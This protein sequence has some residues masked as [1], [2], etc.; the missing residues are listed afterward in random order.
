M[1]RRAF[2]LIELLLVTGI[3]SVLAGVTVTAVHP[4]RQLAQARNT[5][6]RAHI[7]AMLNAVH[8]YQVQ[9]GGSL[10]AGIDATVRMIGAAVAGCDVACFGSGESLVQ[11]AFVDDTQME[12]DAGTHGGTRWG[13]GGG[14]EL[15]GG[16]A[17]TFTSSV[18]DAGKT[19]A[20]STLSWVPVAPYGKELPSA[21][22]SGYA[23]GNADMSG[24]AVL[25][26]QNENSGQ[27]T[28]SS[29]NGKHSSLVAGVTYGGAG[30]FRSALH[31]DG[32]D[33]VEFPSV[34]SHVPHKSSL[35]E[36]TAE[37]WMRTSA[38]FSSVAVFLTQGWGGQFLLQFNTNGEIGFA[39]HQTRSGGTDYNG[40]W[41]G[42]NTSPTAY[43]DGQWHH[44]AGRYHRTENTIK[45]YVDGVLRN[46]ATLDA[47][48]YL[49][50]PPT[51]HPPL[52]GAASQ[53]PN[54]RIYFFTGDLDEAA[55][56]SRALS[57]QEIL[58]RYQRGARTLSL[59]ARS[60]DDAVC[61]GEAFIGPDGTAGSSFSE[62]TNP[63]GGLPSFS[64]SSATPNR[65][66]Q[67]RVT[68]GADS[69]SLTPILASVTVSNT[70]SGASVTPGVCLALTGSLVPTFIP[71]VPHDPSLGGDDRTYY[72]VRQTAQG[73]TL[74]RACAAE[75]GNV[76]EVTR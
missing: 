34:F 32:N 45:L 8:Q 67:Y 50:D 5:Q 37:V 48:E 14:L 52:L 26:H 10:P 42:V 70:A 55:L 27:I 19:A 22:E 51:T 73:R 57:D 25:W 15:S 68:M 46:Q 49:A 59:Q 43:N 31:F 64:L 63:G 12:F 39:V 11:N 41:Y 40:A 69:A 7:S 30:K 36:L 28:D 66:V 20:W 74:V 9:N 65:Y 47:N 71:S 6:R 60:C 13:G 33:Y 72:A 23:S 75:L 2:T 53:Y 29:G 21:S 54:N 1:H 76:I 16:T 35:N 24:L 3:V 61:S 58:D 56:Y 4:A 18:K 44:V 62:L 17:G 38:T